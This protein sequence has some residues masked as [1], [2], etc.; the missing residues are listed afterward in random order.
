MPH[1]LRAALWTLPL[2]FGLWYFTFA[3]ASGNFWLKLCSSALLLSLIG[4]AL[5][6]NA[7][8]DLFRFRRR[9]LWLSPASAILL[10]GMF[11]VGKGVSS[12][13]LPFASTEISG[14]YLIRTQL[15]P[16]V[17][18]FLLMLVMGP[19]EEIYW[20]GF[21]QRNLSASWGPLRGL[22]VTTGL[23][24]GVHVSSLNFT[25]VMA[26]AVCGLFWGWL[27]QREQSLVPVILSHS[28]WDLA[29]FVLFPLS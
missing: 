13:I 3:V 8:R 12:V 22:L 23:Y 28:L 10:Y 20:H 9:D 5:S 25:L 16:V 7:W 17:I 18:G 29:I 11:W 19:A 1:H 6:R 26:A 21:V 4:L 14:I 2:A 27:Y 24:A 15:D